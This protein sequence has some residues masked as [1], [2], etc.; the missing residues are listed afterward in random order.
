MKCSHEWTIDVDFISQTLVFYIMKVRIHHALIIQI[1]IEQTYC[2]VL[3]QSS[4]PILHVHCARHAAGI[5]N[6]QFTEDKLPAVGSAVIP[7]MTEI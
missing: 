1:Q 7:Y 6:I 3:L 4:L 2:I 5:E